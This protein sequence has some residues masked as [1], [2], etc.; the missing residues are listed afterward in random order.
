MGLEG[1]VAS[2]N[3]MWGLQPLQVQGFGQGTRGSNRCSRVC[4]GGNPRLSKESRWWGAGGDD[5]PTDVERQVD[6]RLR[7]KGMVGVFQGI[8][9]VPLGSV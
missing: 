6:K 4:Y 2:M 7:T 1:E 3:V 8:M 9:A 5:L